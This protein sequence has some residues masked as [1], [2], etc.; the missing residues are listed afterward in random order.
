MT[1]PISR[2]FGAISILSIFAVGCT[3]TTE[4]NETTG[5]TGGSTTSSSSSSSSGGGGGGAGGEGTGGSATSSS[6]SS[7]G[8]GGGGGDYVEVP[9]QP[10]G[11][12]DRANAVDISGLPG[13]TI[14]LDADDQDWLKF[15]TPDDGKAHLIT[16]SY[17]Q[18]TS[19][20]FHL[21]VLADADY[22]TIG[23]HWSDKGTKK[24]VY[25]TVG[26][27]AT[28]LLNFELYGGNGGLFEYTL[29]DTPEN[30]AYEPN[31]AREQAA[32]ISL[33]ADVSGQFWI[34]YV[35]EADQVSDDWFKVD[36]TAGDVTVKL[37]HVPANQRY[38]IE[39][40][41]ADFVSISSYWGD[42]LGATGQEVLT[43]KKPGT[44][45]V[46]LKNYGSSQMKDV[47]EVAKPAGLSE[48]YTFRIEQ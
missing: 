43:V 19:S 10:D 9:D 30:D 25:F 40:Y 47:I 7:G 37:T 15:T 8:G 35:A 31:N 27:K 2:L 39:L 32:A 4:N 16:L 23:T 20:G 12:D 44:H 26:P 13:F 42:G 5:G 33:N 41:D 14:S 11:N 18:P 3:I 22:S 48:Q 17:T 34:P 29:T 45:Y 38:Q 21:E 24:T 28:T 1:S 36:L 6:S 46:Q